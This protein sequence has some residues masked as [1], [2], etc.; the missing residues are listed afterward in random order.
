MN[1]N[2]DLIVKN[3]RVVRPH[4]S[5]V[6]LL[7]I[8]IKDGKFARL[9]PEIRAEEGAKV[10]DGKNRLAFPGCV[11]AHMHVGIYQD[12]SKDAVSESKAAAMG[13][14]TTSLNYMRTGQ[15][16]L[17]MG[18]SWR[19]FMPGVNQQCVRGHSRQIRI[20]G[21]GL[22]RG[23]DETRVDGQSARRERHYLAGHLV[24]RRG[25]I[26]RGHIPAFRQVEM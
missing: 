13:G 18:G 15:Y 22:E 21:Q 19:A 2:F 10:I 26:V 20:R 1:P 17:N 16:Y 5:S 23:F 24:E 8:G 25:D 12:L 11:D 14:V 7:D 4:K 6:D 3:V 9:A